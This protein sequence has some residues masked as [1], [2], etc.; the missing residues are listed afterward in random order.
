MKKSNLKHDKVVI[1]GAACK[2]AEAKNKEE[3]WLN[4]LNKKNCISTT[5]RWDNLMTD[6][7]KGGF[8][9]NISYFDNAYFGISPN[10]AQCMDP[11]QRILLETVHHSIED[12]NITLNQLRDQKCGVFVTS[13]PGD[14][15]YEVAK[16]PVKLYSNYSFTGNAFATLSGRISYF[17][18][19]NGPSINTDTACSSSISILHQ[20]HLNIISGNCNVA[21]VA[22]V[23]IFSTPEIFHFAKKAN[24]LSKN[25]ACSVFDDQADGFIPSEGVASIIIMKESEAKRLN[26]RIYA[27]IEGINCNHNGRSNG[28]M[29]PNSASQAELIKTI[30]EKNTISVNQ[31]AYIET[32]GTGTKLGDPIEINGLKQAFAKY[33]TKEIYLGASKANIGHTL[34]VSGLASIIKIIMSFKNQTIPP[35]HTIDVKNKEIDFDRFKLNEKA[36]LWPKDRDLAVISSFGFTGSNGHVVL[37]NYNTISNESKTSNK[38]INLSPYVFC[39]SAATKKSLENKLQQYL[40]Y[41]DKIEEN[42]MYFLQDQLSVHFENC[43]YRIAIVFNDKESLLEV[44]NSNLIEKITKNKIVLIEKACK[45]LLPV[46]SREELSDWLLNKEIKKA[47]KPFSKQPHTLPN[48]PF[49]QKNYWITTISTN[50]INEPKEIMKEHQEKEKIMNIIKE[51][52]A[53]ILGFDISEINVEKSLFDYGI[54]SL[55]VIQVLMPFK[56]FMDNYNIQ[57]LFE[58]ESI[59][60]LVNEIVLIKSSNQAP[61]NNKNETGNQLREVK[62][63][64]QSSLK[65]LCSQNLGKAILLLPPL[66]TNH[67][68]W[69]QQQKFLIKKG[70][71]IYIP[72]YPGNIENEYNKPINFNEIINEIYLF[73]KKEIG[74]KPIPIIGWSLGGCFSLELAIKYPEVIDSMILIS[75]ASKFDQNVFGNTIALHEELDGYKDFLNIVFNDNISIVQK[76]NGKT[77][78][79]VLKAYYDYLEEFD[80]RNKLSSIQNKTLL[81][82]GKK[83]CVISQEDIDKF[84]PLP[85]YQLIQMDNH[86][87]FIPLT[88]SRQFN[89][90]VDQFLGSHE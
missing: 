71:K 16:D 2:F 58:I 62:L 52:I 19:L 6:T 86:G 49:E 12:S 8:L 7:F 1:V 18:D 31:I 80:I 76:I 65:W 84:K 61:L 59:D 83:D 43:S 64:L 69:I 46:N 3:Y 38:K 4:I 9:D 48:Y 68:V 15:K 82:F 22:G 36:I 42:E 21:I 53:E 57:K 29:A 70:Y 90:F 30:Y 33:D 28:L 32:H 55:S 67:F 63:T 87:H 14:Y 75:T 74:I 81:I 10:E 35:I 45:D 56:E 51:R 23:S 5:K 44:L 50:I 47:M 25:G 66:N 39:F 26:L 11:Q 41:L 37:K 85:S 72:I 13:L 17:Y 89:G 40:N 60:Q 54:D 24:M 77:N 20:A 27:S 78:L 79:S 73:I 34:V 88:A